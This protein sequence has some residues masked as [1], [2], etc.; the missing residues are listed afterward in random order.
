[1]QQA[2]LEKSLILGVYQKLGTNLIEDDFWGLAK[3]LVN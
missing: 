3:K 1:M 2:N